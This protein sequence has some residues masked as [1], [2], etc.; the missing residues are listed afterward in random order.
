[1]TKIRHA[2]IKKSGFTLIELV[3]VI[4]ILGLLA[5]VSLPKF[6]DMS[7]QAQAAKLASVGAAITTGLAINRAAI[8]VGSPKGVRFA[9]VQGSNC[10]PATLSKVVD[11]DWDKVVISE[12]D[13]TGCRVLGG[14][15]PSPIPDGICVINMVGASSSKAIDVP[16]Q[17]VFG[18]S[19]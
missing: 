5:A 13:A 4:V 9:S 7:E 2:K 18:D 15:T 8:A 11:V 12:K 10:N 19:L 1:M 14:R 6:I 3:M 16:I 17:C